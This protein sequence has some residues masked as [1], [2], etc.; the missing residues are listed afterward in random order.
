MIAGFQFTL[1]RNGSPSMPWVSDTD[2]VKTHRECNRALTWLGLKLGL[3][4]I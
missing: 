2:K 4:T 3:N 1:E